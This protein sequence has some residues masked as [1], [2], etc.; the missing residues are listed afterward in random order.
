MAAAA[1]DASLFRFSTDELPPAERL[2]L[3]REVVGRSIV[4]LE[5]EPLGEET[6]HFEAVFRRLPGLGI[7]SMRTTPVRVTRTPQL[8]AADGSDD[9]VLSV[10]VTG[11]TVV[12]QLGRSDHVADG[13]AALMLNAEPGTVE[14]GAGAHFLSL[15]VPFA[16]LAP[17]LIDFDPANLGPIDGDGEAMRLLLSYVALVQREFMLA[18]PELRRAFVSHVQDLLALALGATRDFAA[19]AAG[20]GARAAR[21]H[22]IK[23]DIGE[24]LGDQGLSVGSVARRQR[25][26]P[27]YVQRL[28]EADGTTF[29]EFV[30]DRRLENAHRC[31][32]DP[33]RRAE[34]VTTIALECGFADLSYFVRAF[35]RRFGA[36]PSDVRGAAIRAA[37]R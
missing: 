13:D 31:L 27:R 18:A 22:A 20:R 26:T 1:D 30:R 9:L 36:T 17:L 12:S 28:F 11:T 15:R 35:R 5:I 24:R 3:W 10:P 21:M 23:A 32:T 37:G 8:V 19:F 29:S 6:P 25:V 4:K 14:I 2:L 33:R 16:T 34:S 7:A